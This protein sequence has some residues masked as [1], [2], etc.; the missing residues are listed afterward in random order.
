MRRYSLYIFDLDGTL[1][2]GTEPV[3][4]ASETLAQLRRNGAAIRFLTNNSSQ[5]PLAIANKLVRMGMDCDPAEVLT[6]AIGAAIYLSEQDLMRAF[7]VGE[8]GLVDVLA[9]RGIYSSTLEE[10]C[11]VVVV[12]ICKTFTYALM[13]EAMQRIIRGAK[14]V[15]TNA[16]SSYP[17]EAGRLSPGAGAIVASIQTCTGQRPYVV[18]KPN[19]FLVQLAL[20]SASVDPEDALVV[21]DRYETDILS[22][23]AAG[24]DSLLVLTG[25]SVE[26]PD[27][28]PTA[29]RMTELID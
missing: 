6:S 18:G 29:K 5:T 9:A 14:F 3:P 22:G 19:P 12:G 1:Y 27:G 15:A 20:K 10:E 13:D 8:P 28:V 21:G 25:V 17:L 26:A 24:C 2:R 23:V 11:D 7:V 4:G 16:D